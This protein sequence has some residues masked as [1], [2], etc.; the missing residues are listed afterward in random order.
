M[1][2][3]FLCNILALPEDLDIRVKFTKVCLACNVLALPEALS[4][5]ASFTKVRSIQFH[6]EPML[7]LCSIR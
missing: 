1:L 6:A 7:I 2:E 5:H 4:T 3:V